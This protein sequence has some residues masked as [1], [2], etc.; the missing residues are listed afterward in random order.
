MDQ[1][2]L[3]LAIVL[4][5]FI[6]LTFQF[7]IAEPPVPP[8]QQAQT[9]EG[10]PLAPPSAGVPEGAPIPLGEI[11]AGGT[12]PP[13]EMD[14]G[15]ILTQGPR[16][17]IQTPTL[18][19]SISLVGGRIDDLILTRYR[20]TLEEDSDQIVLLSPPGT[21][22]PYFAGFGWTAGPG[23]MDLPGADT[24][25]RANGEILSPDRPLTLTWDNGR[26]L[27]FEQVYEVDEN[28][29]FTITQRVAN[30]GEQKV[31]L[32]PY[33]F[34]SRTGTPDIL[35]FYILHE[36]PLGV[37]DGTLEEVDYSD[38]Q[39]DGPV[40]KTTTGGW[41]G[42]TDKYWLVA[43]VP[44]QDKPVET[45]FVHNA[46]GGDDKYQADY[47]YEG[48]AIQPGATAEST[49][50][51]FVG[52]K[53]VTLLDS[54]RDEGGIVNFDL[55][56]DFGWFYFLTKPLFYVLDYLNEIIGNFGVAILVLTVGIKLLF[57]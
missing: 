37:F 3:V 14:R 39:D 47:L 18:S 33:G 28:Y 34:I 19:G 13:S 46:S 16:V 50:R 15:E 52:A 35:G 30:T 10:V 36:G 31:G 57:F 11:E 23:D 26:G 1:R 40:H 8:D 2:N 9:P 4:S 51:L 17:A 6:L 45:R 56:V 20:E 44:D 55:S 54:Y 12:V 42:I 24:I 25:W 32:Q 7:F 27:R 41:L 22:N 5:I 49:S 38:L 53:V 48:I 43:L 21:T 29:M